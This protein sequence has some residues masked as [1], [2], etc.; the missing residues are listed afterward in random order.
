MYLILLIKVHRVLKALLKCE[1]FNFNIKIVKYP[2]FM[3]GF[4]FLN[5]ENI[6][7]LSSKCNTVIK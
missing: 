6:Y 1:L 4:P 2:Y 3:L 5:E 7:V